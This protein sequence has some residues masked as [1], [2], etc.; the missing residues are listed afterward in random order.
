[1]FVLKLQ[2]QAVLDIT[3][4]Y[5]W[6]EDAKEGLGDE[7]LL[8]VNKGL[9]KAEQNPILFSAISEHFRKLKVSRFPYLVLYEI[10]ENFIFITSIWHTSR[11]PK[12]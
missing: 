8:E 5:I 10:E 12:E 3:D 2:K 11:K 9:K 7:F 4:G 1:M 6:Y